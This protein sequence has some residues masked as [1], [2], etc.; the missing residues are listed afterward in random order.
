MSVPVTLQRD[1]FDALFA[2]LERRGYLCVGP[3]LRDGAIVYD[4]VRRASDLPEGWVDEQAP[5]HY[6]LRRGDAPTL[7]GY[8]VGPH[9]F[10]KYLF[11]PDLRLWRLRREGQGFAR[12]DAPEPVP[13]YA[14]LGVRGCEIAALEVQDRV[15]I[16]RAVAD[17]TYRERR[18]RALVIA[19][20]CTRSA[21]TCFCVSMGTGPAVEGGYDI[22]ITELIDGGH[23]FVLRAGSDEGRA[24]LDELGGAHATH[25]DR[26]QA[27]RGV[28]RCA[29]EQGQRFDAGGLPELL[30]ESLDS[31]HWES[32]AERCL[33]C[34]S[35]TLACPTCFCSSV[36]DTSDLG[37]AHAERWRRWDSCFNPGHSYLHGGEVRPSTASRYR[38]WLTHKLGTW[39]EQFGTSGCVG[40]GRCVTWCPVGIDLREEVE[41]L[42]RERARTAREE[43][44]V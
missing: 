24:I 10:K 12:D 34:A 38:Q 43:Q 3:V 36:E 33:A 4:R 31:R 41:A 19:V 7:F 28:E 27:R 40:C 44:P 11:P 9:S 22:A 39:V 23:R 25:A 14:F 18:A 8:V 20:E 16:G 17:P 37:G 32:V 26:E 15:F 13:R 6:R 21:G 2:V 42:R 35:C 29:A 5:G 30:R 1:G